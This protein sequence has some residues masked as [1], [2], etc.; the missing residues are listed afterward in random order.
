VIRRVD[1]RPIDQF[2]QEELC[3]PLGIEEFYMGI[4]DAVES[5]VATLR[6]EQAHVELENGW[7][8]LQLRVTPPNV[9][10]AEVVNRGDVRRAVIPGG[11]G[12]MNARAIARHYAM[13]A[14]HGALDG[15]RI[16]SEARIDTIRAL[17]V[18]EEDAV[19]GG[20]A[21]RGLGYA[22]GGDP[23]QG[24]AISMGTG[25][26]EFGHGGNG[27]SLGFADPERKLAFGLTKTLMKA[28]PDPKQSTAFVVAEAIRRHV[29]PPS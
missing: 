16:L 25:G 9:T 24:G 11:G 4:P 27:G 17:Q 28:N 26:G 8:E 6:Q 12:I 20:L 7:N 10:T 21:R 3:R 19:S 1:G 5:R 15:V 18:N 29:S 14:C 13:L 2:V 23:A 22:L